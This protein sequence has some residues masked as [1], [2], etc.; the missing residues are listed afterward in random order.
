MAI[1]FDGIN[2]KSYQLKFANAGWNNDE[3]F[4]GKVESKISQTEIINKTKITTV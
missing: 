1:F 3:K 4:M 2:R